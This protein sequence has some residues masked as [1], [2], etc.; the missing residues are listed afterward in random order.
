[1]IRDLE[2]EREATGLTRTVFQEWLREGR[3]DCDA[4]KALLRFRVYGQRAPS[5]DT[6]ADFFD[7]L[8]LEY[9]ETLSE[10]ERGARRRGEGDDEA[11]DDGELPVTR[12]AEILRRSGYTPFDTAGVPDGEITTRLCEDILGEVAKVRA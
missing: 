9:F 4:A 7:E 11:A 6:E 5:H 3:H 12:L 8:Y 2:D 10:D 1:M